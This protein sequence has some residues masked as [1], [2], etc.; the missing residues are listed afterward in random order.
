MK[1]I[2]LQE[3]LKQGLNLVERMASKLTTLPI[4]NNILLKTEKNFLNIAAT[5]LEVGINWW[6][7]AKT[8]EEG[9]LVLPS[10]TISSLINFLPNKP[11]SINS[12]GL[13]ANLECENYKS[14]VK[15]LDPNEFPAIP[16]LSDGESLELPAGLLCEGL[17]RV[18]GI[19]A[20]STTRPEISGVYFIFQKGMVKM[21]ATDSFR[22][23]EKTI[24]NKKDGEVGK[25]RS[26][27]L[28]QKAAR[29]VI[30]IFGQREGDVKIYFSPNQVMF[31]A[32]MAETKHPQVQLVSRL[33]EGEF[34]DYQEI[35]PQTYTSRVAV[36]KKEL[37]NQVK[38][39][40]LF[41]GRTNEIKLKINPKTKGE[42]EVEIMSQSQDL[43][44]YRGLI[45][46]EVKGK[47]L[48][49]SFNHRFL[50]EGLSSQSSDQAKD[51]KNEEIIFELTGED[52]P[53]ILKTDQE[54]GF[55]YVL[56]PIKK[57]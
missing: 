13:I 32:S 24:I 3:K 53:A 11:L 21:V 4:L 56:M 17:S 44:E 1:I 5:D 18:A 22:L 33:I 49:I 51:G 47:G 29:E 7:L 8:E 23:G 12:K 42:G 48:E 9:S 39:A 37:L 38:A 52:G 36:L 34:P 50:L 41:S 40:G 25:D 16:V 31:E 45:R 43:G 6:V 19:A 14:T 20:P 35:I 54:P 26:F 46:S 2:I 30:N 27:I 10:Q 15:S 28:P 57:G 55:V